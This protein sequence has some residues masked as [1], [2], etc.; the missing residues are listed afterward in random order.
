[1]HRSIHGL[2][3]ESDDSLASAAILWLALC[4]EEVELPLVV[5]ASARTVRC[6][7]NVSTM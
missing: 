5:F 2:K 3:I 4:M 6:L 1:M 7:E